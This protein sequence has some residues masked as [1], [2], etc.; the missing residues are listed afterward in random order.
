[1]SLPLSA[2][3]S[4]S[5]PS[6]Y[7]SFPTAT[8]LQGGGDRESTALGNTYIHEA[9]G[10]VHI[11]A[12]VSVRPREGTLR[13]ARLKGPWAERRDRC[14]DES[15]RSARFT[16][17]F[18]RDIS[19]RGPTG[20]PVLERSGREPSSVLP[21]PLPA[22]ARPRRKPRARSGIRRRR[23]HAFG[24]PGRRLGHHSKRSPH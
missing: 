3:P 12:S 9:Y 18:V 4:L 8:G 16:R 6:L 20:A 1:M 19:K 21:P 15:Q 17:M 5:V 2:S 10:D 7:A 24:P 23:G 22:H 11:V 13:R 14:W